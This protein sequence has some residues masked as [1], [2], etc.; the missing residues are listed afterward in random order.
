M[1]NSIK[2]GSFQ[3]FVKHDDAAENFGSNIFPVEQ[4]HKIAILDIL[5]LNCDRNDQNILVQKKS[6][7]EEAPPINSNSN[8]N[9]VEVRATSSSCSPN[10]KLA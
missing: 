5:I 6:I 4:V 1:I 10:G 8:S 9:S 2:Q 7:K 3:C